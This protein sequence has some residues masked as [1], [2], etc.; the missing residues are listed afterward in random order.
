MVLQKVVNIGAGVMVSL[1]VA[2]GIYRVY[3]VPR[4]EPVTVT[5]EVD[6]AKI[7]DGVA[8]RMIAYQEEEETRRSEAA[9]ALFCKK[10][11][12]IDTGG[13]CP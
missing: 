11:A 7:A 10:M 3:V 5:V 9:K 4:E 8:D 1:M 6:E 2:G 12:G 13:R